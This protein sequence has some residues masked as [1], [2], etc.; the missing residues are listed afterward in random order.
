MEI[1][2]RAAKLTPSL[3]LSIDAKAKAMKAEG[4]DVCGF[5][6][7]EP[8]FDTPEHI[9]EAAIAALHAR[10]HEI[11]AERRP[12]RA[13]PGDCGKAAGGQR[14][15]LQAEPDCRQHGRE[16]LLLQR[17][18]RHLPGGRRSHHPRA[19]LG[20]LSGHGAPRGRRAR[21]RAHDRAQRLEDARG[22]FRERDDAAHEDADPEQPEQPFRRRLHARR[23]GGD[24]GSG[25]RGG[26]LHPLRRNLREARL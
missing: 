3:T 2:E 10:I 12:A 15:H 7:G 20:Q 25:G 1:S 14:N 21:D 19:L 5:G 22:R 11:H 9:K 24:R 17:D 26:D 8:D 6:A 16:T 4:I 13:A 23:A 18:S